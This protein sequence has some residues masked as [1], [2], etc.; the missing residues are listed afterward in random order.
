VKKIY[1]S[2]VIEIEFFD[3]DDKVY[4]DD[5]DEDAFGSI[6]INYPSSSSYE[7]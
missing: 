1:T 2:P 6:M 7:F 3:V 4:T 5:F